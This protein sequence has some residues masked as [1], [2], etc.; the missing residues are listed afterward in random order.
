MSA[1]NGATT[2]FDYQVVIHVLILA[3]AG[4]FA[5][6]YSFWIATEYGFRLAPLNDQRH[7]LGNALVRKCF[8]MGNDDSV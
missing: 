6:R 8:E 4:I 1:Q 7:K 3:G 5:V 2:L